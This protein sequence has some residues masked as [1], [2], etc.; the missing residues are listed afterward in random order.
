MFNAF[1]PGDWI[2][3]SGDDD[4]KFWQVLE[5]RDS[6]PW[7]LHVESGMSRKTIRRNT[8]TLVAGRREEGIFRLPGVY[9]DV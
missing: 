1:E 3:I 8:A 4:N 5:V 9:I 7:D 2:H 6:P